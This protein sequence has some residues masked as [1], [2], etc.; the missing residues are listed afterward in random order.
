M[1]DY[2]SQISN[3][4]HNYIKMRGQWDVI[5]FYGSEGSNAYAESKFPYVVEQSLKIKCFVTVLQAYSITNNIIK[6]N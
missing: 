6:K 5:L 2:V 1:R 4:I 3:S